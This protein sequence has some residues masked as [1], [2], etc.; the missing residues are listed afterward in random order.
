MLKEQSALRKYSPPPPSELAGRKPGGG[1][2]QERCPRRL[3]ACDL[4]GTGGALKWGY[5]L[6][7]SWLP[8]K[9]SFQGF[10]VSFKGTGP[11]PCLD[12]LCD[13]G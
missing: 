1:G 8:P 13:L 10:L 7:F 9:G 6:L 12:S 4:F 3:Q 2:G 11:Q 5:N